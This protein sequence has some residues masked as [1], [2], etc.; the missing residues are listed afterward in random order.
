MSGSWRPLRGLGGL[1]LLLALAGCGDGR[2]TRLA[3]L[4][5]EP[6]ESLAA[7]E[8]AKRLGELGFFETHRN[9]RGR[10]VAHGFRLEAADQVVVDATTGLAWQRGGSPRSLPFDGALA[11]VQDL[12]QSRFAGFADWRLPTLE[13][14][15]SLMEPERSASGL[16]LDPRFDPAVWLVWT[17]DREGPV[18]SWVV[19][20][21][22]GSCL[23]HVPLGGS[24]HVRAVRRAG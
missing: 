1:A 23:V 18:G 4:R 8:V 21:Y 16:Y 11:Y 7:P 3:P 20:Y 2:A 13:E 6:A 9:P 15:M 5:S 24:S 22:G 17:A 12:N 14:A 10:G 19:T